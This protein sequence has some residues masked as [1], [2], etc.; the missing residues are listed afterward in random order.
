MFFTIGFQSNCI[1]PK[2][3]CSKIGN[4]P[5]GTLNNHKAEAYTLEVYEEVKLQI[6]RQEYACKSWECKK[7]EFYFDEENI[8]A[9][10]NTYSNSCDVKAAFRAEGNNFE[11]ENGGF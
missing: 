11:L 3:L 9:V 5:L 6:N 2:K 7:A 8:S 1:S 10:L 4:G